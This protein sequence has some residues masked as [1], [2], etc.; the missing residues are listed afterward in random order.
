MTADDR[1]GAPD[2]L[3]PLHHLVDLFVCAPLGF[4]LDAPSLL[5]RWIDRGREQ[6]ASLGDV[7]RVVSGRGS[8][9]SAASRAGK[10]AQ[11]T[12]RGLGLAPEPDASSDVTDD[13]PRPAVSA[14]PPAPPVAAVPPPVGPDVD[15]LAITDYDS[16]SASQVVPRLDGLAPDELESIRAYETANRGRK[17]I[18][19][20]IAQLQAP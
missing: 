13:Q 14:V 3:G 15:T 9:E 12:L 4:V 16:L 10:Q 5:P 7:G 1:G 20:K 11:A 2:H 6:L 17:T 8:G 18:L 19:S